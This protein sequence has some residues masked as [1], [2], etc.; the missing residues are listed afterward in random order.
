MTQ[1][2]F[3]HR[4]PQCIGAI[5]GTNI[6]TWEPV[7]NATDYINR[8]GFSSINAQAT[9]DYKHRFIDV[10]VKWPGSVHVARIFKNSSLNSKLR[11]GFVLRCYK[12]ILDDED[13]FLSAY[14]GIQPFLYYHI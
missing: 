1:R 2:T 9:C 7:D 14:K 6:P 12:T 8:K 3:G 11:D 13:P 5:D 4:F 10:V